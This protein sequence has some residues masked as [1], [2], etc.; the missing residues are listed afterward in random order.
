M[1]SHRLLGLVLQLLC[2]ATSIAALSVRPYPGSVKGKL[3]RAAF[4]CPPSNSVSP[5]ALLGAPP[6]PSWRVSKGAVALTHSQ[7]AASRLRVAILPAAAAS[8]SYTPCLHGQAAERPAAKGPCVTPSRLPLPSSSSNVG[9]RLWRTCSNEDGQNWSRLCAVPLRGGGRG[10]GFSWEETADQMRVQLLLDPS[11]TPAD[12]VFTLEGRRLRVCLKGFQPL[13]EGTLKGRVDSSQCLWFLEPYR[14][15]CEQQQQDSYQP[16]GQQTGELTAKQLTIV[17]EKH[18]SRGFSPVAEGGGAHW[19]A[20]F[21]ETAAAEAA[22][23]VYDPLPRSGQPQK[24]P[25]AD[26]RQPGAVLAEFVIPQA[27][28]GASFVPPARET[29]TDEQQREWE[30]QL[31]KHALGLLDVWANARDPHLVQP[32]AADSPGMRH[33]LFEAFGCPDT[34][35]HLQVEPL[36]DGVLLLFMPPLEFEGCGGGAKSSSGQ[37]QVQEACWPLEEGIELRLTFGGEKCLSLQKQGLPRQPVWFGSPTAA[38]RQMPGSTPFVHT[39]HVTVQSAYGCLL[40]CGCDSRR[41]AFQEDTAHAVA[42]R[43]QEASSAPPQLQFTDIEALLRQ[44]LNCTEEEFR[45]AWQEG[46][47]RCEQYR[48]LTQDTQLEGQ[49][50]QRKQG[51]VGVEEQQKAVLYVQQFD[52]RL[53]S[54]EGDDST[55]AGIKTRSPHIDPFAGPSAD[56]APPHT[57]HEVPAFEGKLPSERRG[58]EKGGMFCEVPRHRRYLLMNPQERSQVRQEIQKDIWRFDVLLSELEREKDRSQW[59]LI[60]EQYKDLLLAESYFLLLTIRLLEAPRQPPESV[61]ASSTAAAATYVGLPTAATEISERGDRQTKEAWSAEERERLRFINRFVHSLYEDLGALL[62]ANAATQLKKIKLLCMQAVQDMSKLNEYAESMKPLFDRDFFA[63]LITAIQEER[64]RIAQEGLNPDAAPSQWLLVLLVIQKG[65]TAL[66]EKEIREDVLDLGFILTQP[67]PDVRR[68]CLELWIA[69]LPKCDWRQFKLLGLRLAERFTS[70]GRQS[71]LMHF[72]NAD[73]LQENAVLHPPLFACAVL[74]STRHTHTAQQR[75]ENTRQARLPY[76]FLSHV[77]EHRLRL[78]ACRLDAHSL[79]SPYFS[80]AKAWL[81][82]LFV[83]PALV[84]LILARAYSGAA[85]SAYPW[86][87]AAARQLAKDLEQLLPDWLIEGMLSDFDRH[88]MQKQLAQ[89]PFL[90]GSMAPPKPPPEGSPESL[91]ADVSLPLSLPLLHC[92]LIFG[93]RHKRDM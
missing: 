5:R 65:V 58:R 32:F 2:A 15:P 48:P 57:M 80:K 38:Q 71:L 43:L 22:G 72:W 75:V 49:L 46:Y 79:A 14:A 77:S 44:Q 13:L 84:R 33:G 59:L 39:L 62:Q 85:V 92:Y 16:Y 24:N 28:L 76:L 51:L 27:L 31:L 50:L 40:G 63:F 64:R 88:V 82:L 12:V 26:Q 37:Q 11:V 6:L 34:L 60:C 35:V 83:G 1:R 4:L 74:L 25:F 42:C 17:L 52:E 93:L 68:R 23:A 86:L 21:E 78:A 55:D 70:G 66:F 91:Y 9:I 30:E 53:N 20:L 56:L 89:R 90:F 61:A 54:E 29:I 73:T 87:P 81:C 36:P 3:A 19:G 67:Q 69:Q 10:A 41:R 7:S 47:D 8:G 45:E 18:R